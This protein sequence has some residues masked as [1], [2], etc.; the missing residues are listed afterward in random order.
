VRIHLSYDPC[1]PDA[2]VLDRPYERQ[3]ALGPIVVPQ[4]FKTDLASTPKAVWR[5][6]PRWGPWSGAAIIHD[7]LYRTK[8]PGL[9]RYE[10]DRIL[11]RLMLEDRVLYGIARVIYRSVREF[12]EPAW[13]HGAIE[14]S[15]EE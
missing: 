15:H 3:T 11:L 13:N 9:S 5:A 6:F 8:P 7:Y 14:V 12:G 10:A 2:W 1:D 4:G